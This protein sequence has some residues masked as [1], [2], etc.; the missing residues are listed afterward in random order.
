LLSAVEPLKRRE[1]SRKSSCRNFL[2]IWRLLPPG[3]DGPLGVLS[4]ESKPLVLVPIG[5]SGGGPIV[6]SRALLGGLL[7]RRRG[8]GAGTVEIGGQCC[9][10]PNPRKSRAFRS[11]GWRMGFGANEMSFDVGRCLRLPMTMPDSWRVGKTPW[12]VRRGCR[13][14]SAERGPD[15][16][17]RYWLCVVSR[18]RCEP[19]AVEILCRVSVR[20]RSIAM[21]RRI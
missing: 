3:K 16:D 12:R 11:A 13:G 19:V 9:L 4:G 18:R 17:C 5:R 14:Y 21:R 2:W 6:A 20:D 8:R 10:D 1:K 15:R 7:A